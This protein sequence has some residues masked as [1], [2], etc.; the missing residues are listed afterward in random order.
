MTMLG[1][2]RYSAGYE[3][4][5]RTDISAHEL[6]A[7][8]ASPERHDRTV[9]VVREQDLECLN[10]PPL[11]GLLAPVKVK[12]S[13]KPLGDYLSG[14]LH[15]RRVKADY[16]NPGQAQRSL[17][18]FLDRAKGNGHAGLG[19]VG[20]P[21]PVFEALWARAEKATT[22]SSLTP[23][24]PAAGSTYQHIVLDRTK[25]LHIPETLRHD[26]VGSSVL[27]E[28]VR[29]LIVCAAQADYPVLVF[30]ETGTGKEIVARQIHTLSTRSRTGSLVPVNCGGISVDLLESELF[31]HAR[32]AFTGAHYTKMGLWKAADNGTLFLD[33]IGDL[34]LRHQVKILRALED[35]GFY[36]VGSTTLVKSNARII[37]ATNRD[38]PRMITE[39]TFREDLFY[40][41]FSLQIPTPPLRDH[42]EDIPELANLFWRGI[43][44][45]KSPALPAAITNLLKAYYWPGNAR[46]LK[47]LLFHV[48]AL[49]QDGA[50]TLE[51]F[52]AVFKERTH[53]LPTPSPDR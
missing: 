10:V 46:E 12:H 18:A 51:L 53:M 30:G 15:I 22:P 49:L 20:V 32:G 3:F 52:Q 42:P 29:R 36:P 5:Q 21:E 7:L 23:M 6:A 17:R 2:L 34:S 24:S 41:L 9:Y 8:F 1:A 16:R 19:L 26:Y 45:P 4:P 47:A 44:I 31:G 28:V 43:G 35:G 39:G 48:S 37:A 50:P 13:A 40:R 27:V 33:E 25:H 11:A 14:T 38:L